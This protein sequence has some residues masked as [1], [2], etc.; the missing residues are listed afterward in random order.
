MIKAD[1]I[2]I[3]Q[4]R[5]DKTNC[6]EIVGVVQLTTSATVTQR[7]VDQSRNMAVDHA[8][9]EVKMAIMYNVYG[10]ILHQIRKSMYDIK[11]A[12]LSAGTYP[13]PTSQ[14]M[15]AVDKSFSDV[16]GLMHEKMKVD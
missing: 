12:I 7:E 10:D 1:K 8:I 6:I 5:H 2:K 4:Y 3:R 13:I 9:R 16:L 11:D 15:E 14:V